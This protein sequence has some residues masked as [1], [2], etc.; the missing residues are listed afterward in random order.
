MEDSPAKINELSSLLNA[1]PFHNRYTLQY[2]IQLLVKVA[3]NSDSNKMGPSNL[4]IVFG[5]T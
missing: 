1:I 4:S 3:A 2:L 5:T